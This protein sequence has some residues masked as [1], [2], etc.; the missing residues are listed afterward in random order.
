M[1]FGKPAIPFLLEYL[2][3]KLHSS[4]DLNRLEKTK[5]NLIGILETI[6]SGGRLHPK[7]KKLSEDIITLLKLDLYIKRN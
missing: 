1:L 6:M 2:S 7:I 3:Q 5:H 4:F